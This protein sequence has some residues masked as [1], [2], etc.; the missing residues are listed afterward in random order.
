M[1]RYQ[2]VIEDSTRPFCAFTSIDHRRYNLV[3]STFFFTE[4]EKVLLTSSN[5]IAQISVPGQARS[6]SATAGATNIRHGQN[7]NSQ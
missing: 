6:G 4:E 1:L 5:N 7:T 3:T 2:V